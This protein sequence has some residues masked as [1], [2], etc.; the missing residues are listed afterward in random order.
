M[1]Y[2]HKKTT[3]FLSNKT[4]N[5]PK[6]FK[7]TC[8]IALVDASAI[9]EKVK[10]TMVTLVLEF[11]LADRT[12]FCKAIGRNKLERDWLNIGIDFPHRVHV[13]GPFYFEKFNSSFI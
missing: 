2:I 4:K 12:H 9:K 1:Q 7:K 5:L 3:I 6:I 13:Q 8:L 11:S 10:V